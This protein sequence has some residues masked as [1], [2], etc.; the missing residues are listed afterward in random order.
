M[1]ERFEVWAPYAQRVELV[2]DGGRIPMSSTG[3]GW[4]EAD[5]DAAPGAHYGFSLDGGDPLPDPRSAW[6][7]NGPHALS[8]VV[9]HSAFEW[10]DGG[11]RGSPLAAGVIYELHIG[12][13]TD[14]GTFE[15]AIGRLPHLVDLGVTAVELLPVAEFSGDHGWG[16]DGVDLFAP[17]HAYGEPD[18]LKRLVDACHAHGLAV[19]MDVV[20]NHLG[21]SGNYLGQYGPYFT[22]RYATPW[23]QAVNFDGAG[24]AAVRAFFIENA[25]MW[26]DDYHCDGLRLDAV[27]AILDSS[28]LHILEE[29]AINVERLANHLGRDLFTI[30]ESDLN[31]P[32]VIQRR[33]AG[34]YGMDAQWS[35]DFHHALHS[36]ITG[37]TNGYYSDFGNVEH[38]AIALE[39]AFVY[40]GRY[41]AYRDRVHGRKPVGIPG[42]RFLAYI[43]NHDQI[44]NRA[45]G[46][47]LSAIVPPDLLKVAAALVLTSPFV[48][49]LFQGEEWGATTPFLYFTNHP[50][51]EL[52]RAVSEGRKREFEAFGW[53]PA[54][55]PDPQDPGSFRR[56]KLN[57]DEMNEWPHEEVL[58]WHR[59]LIGLRREVPALG[60]GDLEAVVTAFDEDQRALVVQRGPVVIA[61]NFSDSDIEVPVENGDALELLLSSSEETEWRDDA[62]LL[63]PTS[64]AIWSA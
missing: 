31:D 36:V 16:Y 60:D 46:N 63:P 55:I 7:P 21:P 47:R 2:L 49:M 12:T 20:Y 25:L 24:S 39:E 61:A 54:S 1:S 33:E 8:R 41:S 27:H 10:S 53:D 59:A 13:F 45:T 30:A 38:L 57:W 43:Q 17:H 4:F 28:A 9:D 19:I 37:E 62:L 52:G 18:D 44:G 50:D 32:R 51:E 40:G 11:W 5:A 29:I 6:Q 26:L 34:G 22:E 35:D 56:S 23:G 64:V 42:K 58:E 3:G 48:P 14:E 15:A